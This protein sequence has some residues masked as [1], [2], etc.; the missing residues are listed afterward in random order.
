METTFL[1]LCWLTP[2]AII[3]A[4]AIVHGIKR[5]RPRRPY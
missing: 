2:S 3:L 5:R 1:V 4:G